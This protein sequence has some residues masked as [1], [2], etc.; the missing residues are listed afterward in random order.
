MW[1]T[2]S[3]FALL[4]AWFRS[5]QLEQL[6]AQQLLLEG[7]NGNISGGPPVDV[8]NSKPWPPKQLIDMSLEQLEF[9]STKEDRLRLCLIGLAVCA[10]IG[11]IESEASEQAARVWARSL[12]LD[13]K[14]WM[15]WISTHQD[16]TDSNLRQLALDST[17]FGALVQECRKDESLKEVAYGRHIEANVMKHLG[18]N[19]H[20]AE[21]A[22][23]LR[24]VTMLRDSMQGKS[25]VVAH[26]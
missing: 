9:A 16:L 10:S 23:L 20:A 5:T 11:E 26:Y 14:S 13:A 18:K 7:R 3:L 8:P 15:R 22:R 21:M 19:I 2:Y 1:S 4:L 12:E 24:S 6:H 17:V 25:L